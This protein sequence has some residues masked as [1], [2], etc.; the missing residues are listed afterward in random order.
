M[1][2]ERFSALMGLA[3]TRNGFIEKGYADILAS[4]LGIFGTEY[5]ALLDAVTEE[6]SD[7]IK[8]GA[9]ALIDHLAKATSSTEAEALATVLET[10]LRKDKGEEPYTDQAFLSDLLDFLINDYQKEAAP[11]R[12]A[13]VASLIPAPYNKIYTGVLEYAKEHE[14]TP[15][16][17][18]GLI[19]LIASYVTDNKE[20]EDVVATVE[21]LAGLVPEKYASMVPSLLS[22]LTGKDYPDELYP[23]DPSK[24]K[25]VIFDV[26]DCCVNGSVVDETVY[27][28][29]QARYSVIML[30]FL[31]IGMQSSMPLENLQNLALNG[32]ING[33]E[34]IVKDPVPLSA[35]TE[36]ILNMAMPFDEEEGG[37]KTRVP[38][39]EAADREIV[40][41]LGK[42]RTERNAAYIDKLCEHP[43]KIREIAVA[44]LLMPGETFDLHQE[45]ENAITFIETIQFVAPAHFQEMYVC[46]LKTKIA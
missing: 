39:G 12:F 2:D 16:T 5:G 40:S 25:A 21:A 20:D 3:E 23:D 32:A 36:D 8:I 11:M 38:S 17:I 22:G 19:E 7:L 10:L 26:M 15:H 42:A 6:P 43:E 4:A 9:Y 14:M 34:V 27:S 35:I 31:V 37:E 13:V 30:A 29:G 41:L 44:V 33:E 24:I 46:Y 28:P 45:I 18:D 1:L